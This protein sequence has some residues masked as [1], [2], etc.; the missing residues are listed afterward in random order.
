MLFGGLNKKICDDLHVYHIRKGR[1]FLIPHMGME[2]DARYGHSAC[3]RG[4]DAYIFGGCTTNDGV[5][6]FRKCLNTNVILKSIQLEWQ[7]F[8]SHGAVLPVRKY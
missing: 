6:K 1:W 8:V 5:F 2:T 3:L 4:M 7:S